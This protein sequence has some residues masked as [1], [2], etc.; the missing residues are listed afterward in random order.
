MLLFP[1]RKHF[2]AMIETA[3]ALDLASGTDFG[4]FLH[5]RILMLVSKCRE[6]N[7]RDRANAATSEKWDIANLTLNGLD[8]LESS[9][10]RDE[11]PQHSCRNAVFLADKASIEKMPKKSKKL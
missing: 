4:A 3:I 6:R 1:F 5:F 2:Q 7:N 10:L 8:D 11:A 9:S